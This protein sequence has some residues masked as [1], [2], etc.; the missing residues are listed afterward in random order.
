MERS[1]THESDSLVDEGSS[2]TRGTKARRKLGGLLTA[3]DLNNKKNKRKPLDDTNTGGEGDVASK[4]FLRVVRVMMFLGPRRG[5]STTV[6]DAR[7]GGGWKPR[8]ELDVSGHSFRRGIKV[9]ELC[10]AFHTEE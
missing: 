1:V 10:S 9:S 3:R 8:S 5:K 4:D 2:G 7:S 6:G